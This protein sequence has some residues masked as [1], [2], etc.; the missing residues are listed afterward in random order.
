MHKKN[1]FSLLEM[2]VVLITIA[3]LFAAITQSSFVLQ[4]AK[5]SSA[6]SMTKS[7]VVND[8]TGLILWLE[9][10]LL[11]SFN[12][13]QL[14][15]GDLITNWYDIKSSHI[16]QY[17]TTSSVPP[18]YNY[19]AINGLPGISFDNI[20]RFLQISN[21]KANAYMTL[22]VVG[23]F[24]AGD[25]FIEHGTN[26][27]SV[28]GFNFSGSGVPTTIR[29]S[30]NSVANASSTNWLGPETSIA[31]MRYNGINISY[32]KNNSNFTNVAASSVPNSMLEATL[33]IGSRAG[34][35]NFS[36]GFFGEIIMFDRSLTDTEV[37]DIVEYLT[38]KWQII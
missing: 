36:D 17:I 6:R 30:A 37:D 3:V 9:S 24:N 2:S 10:T 16:S 14:N 23:K 21:F 15:D 26:A 33:Y 32:K 35:S 29:R 8:T 18:S 22:F 19:A 27:T 12:D 28:D 7:S 38:K 34:T 11:D 5:L 1:A 20:N 25:M 13:K 4:M 31:V